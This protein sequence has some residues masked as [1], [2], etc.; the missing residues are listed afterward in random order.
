MSPR[1]DGKPPAPKADCESLIRSE[2]RHR[3]ARELHDTTSQTL[4]V[5]QLQLGRFRRS[6]VGNAHPLIQEVEETIRLIRDSIRG[7]GLK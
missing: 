7:L 3:F 1:C 4:V 5:M 6:T 2:E